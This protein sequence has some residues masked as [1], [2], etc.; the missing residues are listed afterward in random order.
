VP[1]AR[2]STKVPYVRYKKAVFSLSSATS[3]QHKQ[4]PKYPHKSGKLKPFELELTQAQIQ[5]AHAYSAEA[6][7]ESRTGAHAVRKGKKS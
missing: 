2:A 4:V 3:H 5:L 6:I 7:V 1:L